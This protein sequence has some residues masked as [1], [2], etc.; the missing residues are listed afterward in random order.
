MT[1]PKEN[2]K[3][4]VKVHNGDDDDDDE[5]EKEDVVTK[6]IVIYD[7]SLSLFVIYKVFLTTSFINY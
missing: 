2:D 1:K 4:F 6:W 7:Y 3:R 5:E